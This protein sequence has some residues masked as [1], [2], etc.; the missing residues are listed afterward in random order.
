MP[1]RNLVRRRVVGEC[2]LDYGDGGGGDDPTAETADIQTQLQHQ[3]RRQRHRPTA[4][5]PSAGRSPA[6]NPS[7]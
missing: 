5:L 7:Q 1:G 2:H 3:Q 6:R 4:R